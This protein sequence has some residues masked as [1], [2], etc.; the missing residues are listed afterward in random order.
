[1]RIQLLYSLI[2]HHLCEAF[3]GLIISISALHRHGVQNCK[4]TLKKLEKLTAARNSDRVVALRKE[5]LR[6]G[7]PHLVW[8]VAKIA[9]SSTKQGSIYIPKGIMDVLEEAPRRKAPSLLQKGVTITIL[10][11]I[12]DARVID[13]SLRKPQAVSASK[14]RKVDGKAVDAVNG[15]IGTR[16]EHFL[17]YLQM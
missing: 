4:A 5:K 17:A 16:T 1:M 14:K 7:R 12:S 15:R 3:P 2:K 13:I 8:P 9:C 10:G 11:A 6:N